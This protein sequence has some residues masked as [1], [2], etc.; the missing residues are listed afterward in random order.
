M[1]SEVSIPELCKENQ[2]LNYN[3]RPI[4]DLYME[5]TVTSAIRTEPN[6]EGYELAHS[7]LADI[8][9]LRLLHVAM[10]LCTEAGE[11]VDQL[12]KHIFYGKPLDTVNLIE[13]LGDSSWYERIG[14]DALEIGYLDMLERNIAKLRARFPEKF[15]EE[16]AQTRDLVK[17]RAILESDAGCTCGSTHG[18]THS[19]NC[20][21]HA[22]RG[23]R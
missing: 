8:R 21:I 3:K 13:E 6:R 18:D 12:K 19:P 9:T 1:A 14:V 17:E 20:E 7:R 11:F 22:L 10:G 16:H 15:S 5:D 4:A 23:Q 2:R